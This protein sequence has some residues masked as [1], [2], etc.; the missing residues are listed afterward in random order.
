MAVQ[1]AN[2]DRAAAMRDANRALE[3]AKR[4]AAA[5]INSA[6]RNLQRAKD[7]MNRHFGACVLIRSAALMHLTH[8]ALP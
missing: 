7:D 5:A 3:Y 6:V 2:N 1:Q 4:D 8:D